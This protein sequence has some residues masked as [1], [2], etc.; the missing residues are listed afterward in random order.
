M[1]FIFLTSLALTASLIAQTK[2]ACVGDSITF[3]AGIAAREK[4]NYPAQLGYLL[5]DDYEVR[6]FAVNGSTM[7]NN[8]DQPF[9]KTAAYKNS[10]SYQ[11]DI[12]IIKLGTNDSKP[13]NW[14]FKAEFADDTQELIQSY[15]SLQNQARVILCQP[16]PVAKD[17]SGIT[18]EVTRGEIAPLVRNVALQLNT[19]LVDLHTPLVNHKDWIPVS[20]TFLIQIHVVY[21]ENWNSTSFT[22]SLEMRRVVH[23]CSHAYVAPTSARNVL[24]RLMLSTF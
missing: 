10:L 4:L 19:E 2:I 6:N 7:L 23:R 22:F 15:T 8:G 16:V 21:T 1:K 12:V 18:E 20:I 17:K 3:G 5:G 11:P 9:T 13:Q 14:K 24:V